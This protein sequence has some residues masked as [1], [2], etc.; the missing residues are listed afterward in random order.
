MEE[1]CK[2]K[3]RRN[4]GVLGVNALRKR[5]GSFRKSKSEFDQ[6]RSEEGLK[7]YDKEEYRTFGRR[8]LQFNGGGLGH[9]G[10]HFIESS[11]TVQS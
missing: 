11:I 5:V 3:L 7:T 4:N 1:M 8:G 2:H 9:G 10:K 6:K